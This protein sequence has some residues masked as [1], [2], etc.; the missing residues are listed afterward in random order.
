MSNQAVPKIKFEDE[1][2]QNLLD[3]L[4]PKSRKADFLE[5]LR[6]GAEYIAGQTEMNLL[7]KQI[8]ESTSLIN[9]IVVW[10]DPDAPAAYVSIRPPS[11]LGGDF[12]LAFFENG[13]EE[14]ALRRN[15]KRLK[16]GKR[17]ENSF[18]Q[19]PMG[20]RRGRIDKAKFGG[21]FA[22]ATR[23]EAAIRKTVVAE[24]ELLINEI[25]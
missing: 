5:A 4:D 24:L 2:V 22:E 13:T 19:Y 12:R 7:R 17:D 9:G 8:K 16:Y 10:D 14:R 18:K 20:A 15:G 6:K 3:R 1:E 21:F 23:D 25:I 11:I